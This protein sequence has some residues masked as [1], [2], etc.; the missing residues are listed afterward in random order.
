MWRWDGTVKTCLKRV[1][2]QI[3]EVRAPE[4]CLVSSAG[5]LSEGLPLTFPSPTSGVARST[6]HID[7]FDTTPVELPRLLSKINALLDKTRPA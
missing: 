5:R 4:S 1:Q 6:N 7:D 3:H 2:V